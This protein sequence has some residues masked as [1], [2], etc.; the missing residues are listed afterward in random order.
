MSAVES[1]AFGPSSQRISSAAR[2]F[3]AVHVSSATTATASSSRTT[4]RTPGMALAFV[5]STAPTLPPNTGQAA[6]LAYFMPGS[7]TSIP[8][9]VVPSTLS[10]VS[11]RFTDVPIRRKSLGSFSATLPGTGRRAAVLT[12]AP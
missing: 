7:R 11:S 8:Y 10:G 12:S 3:F 2:P 1:V 5:S 9:C 6:T 4:C